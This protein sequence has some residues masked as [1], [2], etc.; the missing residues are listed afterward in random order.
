MNSNTA[1]QKNGPASGKQNDMPVRT[2]FQRVSALTVV[3]VLAALLLATLVCAFAGVGSNV[4]MALLY[5][6]FAVPIGLWL[7]FFVIRLVKGKGAEPADP[8]DDPAGNDKEASHER[9]KN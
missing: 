7:F 5:C 1:D 4:L 8:G 9:K 3:I 6:D 2:P